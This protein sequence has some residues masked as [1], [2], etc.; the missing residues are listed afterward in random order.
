MHLRSFWPKVR[1]RYSVV[2]FQ[3]C[4]TGYFFWW[5]SERVALDD[6]NRSLVSTPSHWIIFILVLLVSQQFLV[7]L[8]FGLLLTVF[9]KKLRFRVLLPLS[10]IAN[11]FGQLSFLGI[12]AEVYRAY[13]CTRFGLHFRK[14]ILC[15]LLDRFLGLA[16]LLVITI[17]SFLSSPNRS[18]I[19]NE[20]ANSPLLRGVGFEVLSMLILIGAGM[21]ITF[22]IMK[23]QII[24]LILLE[25]RLGSWWR[26]YGVII[27]IA[28]MVHLISGMVVFIICSSVSIELM[29][30]DALLLAS[31][32][33]L[34]SLIPLS[35]GGWGARELFYYSYFELL[36]FDGSIGFFVGLTFGLL[37]LSVA[38]IGIGFVFF[39]K[40]I[41]GE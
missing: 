33:L 4:L 37:V 32:G 3:T 6:V 13:R 19:T 36:G 28:T 15:A 35:L 25:I 21:G 17:V 11:L 40:N 2:A 12:G 20:V 34:T 8:R 39:N 9:G 29:F 41:V 14:A 31:L 24:R 7:A 23:W 27:G 5:L 10:W 1:A 30:S 38:M 16:V 18:V 26:S 22:V